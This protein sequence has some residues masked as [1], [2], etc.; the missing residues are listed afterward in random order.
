VYILCVA[1]MSELARSAKAFAELGGRTH[2]LV[3]DIVVAL[4]DMGPYHFN[5]FHYLC[6]HTAVYVELCGC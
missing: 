3:A 4:V 1:V 5:F 2:P 6:C